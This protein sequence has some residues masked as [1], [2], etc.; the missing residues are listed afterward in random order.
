M[1]FKDRAVGLDQ[2]LEFNGAVTEGQSVG[3]LFDQNYCL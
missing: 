2:S 3:E 1:E